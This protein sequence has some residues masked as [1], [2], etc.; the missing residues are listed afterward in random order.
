MQTV[1]RQGRKVLANAWLEEILTTRDACFFFQPPSLDGGTTLEMKQ[2]F[3]AQLGMAWRHVRPQVSRHYLAQSPYR[4]LQRLMQG[5]VM[6]AYPVRC[7]S[8]CMVRR[9]RRGVGHDDMYPSMNI[10]VYNASALAAHG[11]PTQ[12]INQSPPQQEEAVD[13]AIPTK[14]VLALAKEY[15]LGLMG[16]KWH[17]AFLSAA[18]VKGLKSEAVMRGE[19]LALF[20]TYQREVVQALNLHH[21]RET[22]T[23]PEAEAAEAGERKKE[24][25]IESKS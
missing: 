16:A 9:R 25:A 22:G 24:G 8:I 2:K 17:N 14:Q 3:H 18:E 4:E 13:R 11:P 5:P 19:V 10:R 15:N 21:E 12:S 6:V 23:G 1:V 7:V 20:A